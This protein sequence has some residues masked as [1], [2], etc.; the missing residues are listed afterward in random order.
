VADV[1]GGA[2]PITGFCAYVP[3]FGEHICVYPGVQDY[4]VDPDLL[5]EEIVI[6]CHTAPDGQ[7]SPVYD[8]GDCDGDEVSNGRDDDP[9]SREEPDAGVVADAG[10]TTDAGAA[11]DAG[12]PI[13]P[14][15]GPPAVDASTPMRD[16]GVPESDAGGD[17]PDPDGGNVKDPD[18]PP[19]TRPG[20]NYEFRGKGG[21]SCDLVPAKGS[22]TPGGW[23]VLLALGLLSR[24]QRE[25][26]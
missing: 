23:L 20:A 10:T 14:D 2:E 24:R 1:P 18:E 9:C 16:A 15:A 5:T 17:A 13:N 3:G 8:L 12:L 11:S 22:S 4:C 26:L 25:R 19:D 21:C 6:D 7:T